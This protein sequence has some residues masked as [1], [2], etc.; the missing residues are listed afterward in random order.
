MGYLSYLLRIEGQCSD[1]M[2][3]P[4]AGRFM[5]RKSG[6][7]RGEME[8]GR[9]AASSNSVDV[10]NA[11]SARQVAGVGAGAAT[12]ALWSTRISQVPAGNTMSRTP[13]RQRSRAAR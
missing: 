5:L 4:R 8:D 12:T 13:A 1:P 11:A 3:P 9:G 6:A 10:A 2:A 7:P